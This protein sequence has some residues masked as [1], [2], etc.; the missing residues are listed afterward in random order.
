MI[1]QFHVEKL[2]RIKVRVRE[3]I[4]EKDSTIETLAPQAARY[5][6]LTNADGLHTITS[7]AKRYG[8][9]GTHLNKILHDLHV[10][11]YVDKSWCLYQNIINKYG[12]TL[13]DYVEVPYGDGDSFR[14]HL[15]WTAQGR[16]FI[17]RALVEHKLVTDD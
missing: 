2:E 8:W 6:K 14:S 15:R 9:S 16:E 12:N 7:I 13:T 4:T 3:A 10:Q 17:H 1:E 5:E 11:Y